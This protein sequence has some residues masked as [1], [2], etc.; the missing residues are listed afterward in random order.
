MRKTKPPVSLMNG[1]AD[2]V[3]AAFYEAMLND[4]DQLGLYILM[5]I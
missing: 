4:M 2:E 3:E 5:L 1:T